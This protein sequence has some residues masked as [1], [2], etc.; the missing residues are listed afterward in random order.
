L[1]IPTSETFT[2]EEITAA[3]TFAE[4]AQTQTTAKVRERSSRLRD[5]A[6]EHFAKKSPDKRLHCEVCDWAPA[7]GLALSGPI[8]EIHHGLG[9]REYPAD[10]R[11]MTFE[12]AIQHLT[13]L[14]P[15]CHRIAHAK[16]GGGVFTLAELK[17]G[18]GAPMLSPTT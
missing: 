2:P 4:G 14:C 17:Q 3:G 1:A 5:L 11:T 6:R 18:V 13:P 8:V 15:N 16:L 10:G 9:I 12:E 7:L